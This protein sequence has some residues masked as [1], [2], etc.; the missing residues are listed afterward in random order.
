MTTVAPSLIT[1][2]FSRAMATGVSPRYFAWS[3]AIGVITATLASTTLVASQAPPMPTSTTAASTGA[4]AKAAYAMPTTVSKNDRGWSDSASTRC[5]YGATSLNAVTK[6]SS[7]IGSPS[8]LIRSVI[9]SRCGLVNRPTRSPSATI[10]VS[11]IR[12]VE[13]FPLVPVRWMT[14]YP[15]CGSPS[16]SVKASMRSRVGSSLVSGQRLRSA[17]STSA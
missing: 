15:R 13:V 8:R 12:A 3:T 4:S 6:A 17:S 10:K 9:D 14:G 16:S 1:P 7:L 2:T 11:I 5:V